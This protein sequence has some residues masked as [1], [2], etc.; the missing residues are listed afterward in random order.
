MRFILPIGGTVFRA[1]AGKG[2]ALLDEPLV[3]HGAAEATLPGA[4]QFAP[5][6][7]HD[8]THHGTRPARPAAI[9]RIAEQEGTLHAALLQGTRER[10]VDPFVETGGG[11]MRGRFLR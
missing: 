2:G 5:G 9:R 11:R 3:Q 1:A 6:G 7:I 10:A 8:I 4:R